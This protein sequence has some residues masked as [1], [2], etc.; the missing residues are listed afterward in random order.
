MFRLR[1]FWCW[2]FTGHYWD[3]TGTSQMMA[4]AMNKC[5]ICGAIEPGPNP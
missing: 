4:G 5:H 3:K 1:R 2:F